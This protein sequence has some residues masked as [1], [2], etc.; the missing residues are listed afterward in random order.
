MFVVRMQ[1]GVM[2]NGLDTVTTC[3]IVVPDSSGQRGP[4]ASSM[5]HF[6]CLLLYFESK[7]DSDIREINESGIEQVLQGV[8]TAYLTGL[9]LG[10]RLDPALDNR[11]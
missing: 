9:I 5:A 8:E 2:Q 4:Q 3:S 1:F 7:F 11:R 6:V 10:F